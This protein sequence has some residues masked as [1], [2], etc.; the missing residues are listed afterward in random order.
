MSAL[1]DTHSKG[2]RIL[3]ISDAWKP[4]ITG[5]VRTYEHLSEELE[6]MGHDVKV[7]GPSDF[8][9]CLPMPF[10]KEIELAPLPYRRLT[11]M[12]KSYN[13]TTALHIATEG[14]LGKAARRYCLKTGMPFVT[15]YHTQFPDYV[16]GRVAKVAP[17]LKNGAHRMTDTVLRRFHAP[18]QSII[19]TTSSLE[20]ELKQRGYKT[21]MHCLIRGVPV[22]KFKPGPSDALEGT[23][24]PIALYVGRVAT[25]KN[26]KDFLDMKWHGSKVVVGSGPSLNSYKTKYPHVYFAGRK[27]GDELI[28]YYRAA[29]IFVFPSRTDTFGIVLLEA[30][31]CGL[32]VAAYDVTGPRDIIT[33]DFLGSLHKDDL[34][35]AAQRALAIK[36]DKLIRYNYICKNYTWAQAAQGFM[37]IMKEERLPLLQHAA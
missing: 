26:I 11:T 32:P 15:A 1:I 19:I 18:A 29:D 36:D 33:K 34:A 27:T 5:V 31:A 22:D 9:R 30:M 3:I 21:K 16:A 28:S 2:E 20:E 17:F 7:I 25:E 35:L 8:P 12:I 13:P 10:Y 23:P 14:P 6:A 24:G 37:E 4:Q